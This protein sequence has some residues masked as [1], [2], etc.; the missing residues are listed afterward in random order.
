MNQQIKTWL[1]VAVIVV[2]T[3]TAGMFIYYQ[4]KIMP[5]V[6]PP[7][8]VNVA[9][10][11]NETTSPVLSEVEGWQTYR[12][13]KYRFE[14]KY[15]STW[16]YCDEHYP[17]SNSERSNAN[18]ISVCDNK[19]EK[20]LNMV[21]NINDTNTAFVNKCNELKDCVEMYNNLRNSSPGW[22]I[23]NNQEIMLS[24]LEAISQKIERKEHGWV[25]FQVLALKD[26]NL[27]DLY[28]TTNFDNSITGEKIYNQILSTFKFIE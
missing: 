19:G 16:E 20:C 18:S 17:A 7:V 9:K 21:V 11:V 27:L 1:G 14:F 8:Q 26:E 5:E 10:K 13:E 15:P 28:F 3:L 25:H 23:V 6:S 4:Q 24:G 12:N 2:I 22:V